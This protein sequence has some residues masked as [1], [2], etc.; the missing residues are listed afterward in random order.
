M[1]AT[2]RDS[3]SSD[4]LSS[5]KLILLD[6]WA[7][8]CAP[9]RGL[10]PVIDEISEKYSSAFDVV[11]LDASIDMEFAQELG[12]SGLPTFL[13]YKDGQIVDSISGATT[14]DKIEEMLKKNS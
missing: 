11:K 9:C 8:F 4:V 1:K 6:V 7:P 14:K 10:E 5:K 3:F 2:N 12:I 13:V